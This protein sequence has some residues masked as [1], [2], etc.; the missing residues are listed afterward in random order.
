M[1]YLLRNKKVEFSGDKKQLI[2]Y[3]KEHYKEEYWVREYGKFFETDFGKFKFAIET[4]GLELSDK[5]TN[6]EYKK[7]HRR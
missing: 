1:K 4:L 6:S 2:A 5:M 7:T 3:I